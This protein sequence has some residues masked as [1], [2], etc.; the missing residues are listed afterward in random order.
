M[1]KC[2]THPDRETSYLC[3]KHNIHM[4][5]ECMKCRDPEIYCKY[6][7]SCPVSFLSKK[8]VK[9]WV[10]EEKKDK[11]DIETAAVTHK[12]EKKE[13]CITEDTP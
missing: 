6:R 1:G 12:T 13:I 3:M 2:A 10:G 4:C 8:G 5:E 11:A 7:S 9:D